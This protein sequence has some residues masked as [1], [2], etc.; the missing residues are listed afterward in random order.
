M[1]EQFFYKIVANPEAKVS[2]S[3]RFGYGNLD[4]RRWQKK[5]NHCG[6]KMQSPIAIYTRR[7]IPLRMPAL[8]MVGYRNPLPGPLKITNNG[9]SVSLSIPTL[10][11][12]QL[13]FG[14]LPYI[15]GA[16]LEHEYEFEGLHFHWGERNS[17]GSEHV[18]NDIRY[19]L[20]MHIIH[21]NIKY[22]NVAE[23]LNHADGLT[24]LAFFYQ[25]KEKESKE[26]SHIVRNFELIEQSDTNTALNYTFSLAS[27][28]PEDLDRFYTYKGSLTTPPCSEAV[29]WIVFPDT[30]S[31]SVFQMQ[32][33]RQL[34]N[35]LEDS[36]LVDNF[37]HLQPLNN[38]RVFVRKL[39]TRKVKVETFNETYHYSKWDWLVPSHH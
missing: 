34:S 11:K 15:F 35:G 9:H 27:L 8:E 7:S 21:R 6:G 4:Q 33:F 32:K 25:L 16:R 1:D 31:I 13:E 23:A 22:S 19:P 3:H 26:L 5:H 20:E 36:L 28:L 10:E 17:R 30:L 39:N 29:T 12:P 14:R 38:R 18:L 37:R 2:H 24:V